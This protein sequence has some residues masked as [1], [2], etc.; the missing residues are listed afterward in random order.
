MRHKGGVKQSGHPFPLSNSVKACFER[1]CAKCHRFSKSGHERIVMLY[2]LGYSPAFRSV[3]KGGDFER[4]GFGQAER[5]SSH[6]R[7]ISV[8]KLKA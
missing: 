7:I 3:F 2:Y 5:V 1:S 8:W 6:A 4:V